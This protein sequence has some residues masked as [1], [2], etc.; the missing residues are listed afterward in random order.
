MPHSQVPRSVAG[1]NSLVTLRTSLLPSRAE[2][3]PIRFDLGAQSV[4]GRFTHIERNRSYTAWTGELDVDSGWFS[5]VRAGSTYRASIVWPH[6][7]YEVTRARGSRYWLTAVA[8]YAGPPS[9]NDATTRD[10]VP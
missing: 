6:G 1:Q 3:Q 8:P 4:T 9:G 7:L 5:I 2:D 10:R